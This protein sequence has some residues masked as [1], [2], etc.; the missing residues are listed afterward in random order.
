PSR[1]GRPADRLP[2]PGHLPEP[3]RLSGRLPEQGRLSGRLPE[4]G[5]SL[6]RLLACLSR[7]D[8]SSGCLPA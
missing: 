1:A 8:R 5:R 6:A 4:L 7:A 2:A 3:G